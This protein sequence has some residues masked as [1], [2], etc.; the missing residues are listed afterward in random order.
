MNKTN[1][2]HTMKTLKAMS[3][4]QLDAIRAKQL[5]GK[6]GFYSPAPRKLSLILDILTTQGDLGCN[7]H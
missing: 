5:E 2:N 1:S 3:R 6:P 4:K 7:R